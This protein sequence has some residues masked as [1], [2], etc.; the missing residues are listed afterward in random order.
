MKL[1]QICM[2]KFDELNRIEH[3][4]SLTE[5]DIK[6]ALETYDR[7]YYNFTIHD[8]EKLWDIKI[9][10]NYRSLKQLL[11]PPPYTWKKY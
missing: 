1:K 7:Q 8:I 6:F 5:E 9:D 3:S 4:N 11:P 2:D 10:R